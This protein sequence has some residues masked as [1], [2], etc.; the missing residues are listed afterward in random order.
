MKKLGLRPVV[1]RG[2]DSESLM[3]TM[4]EERPTAWICHND[5]LAVR[6]IDVLQSAGVSVPRDVSVLGVDDSPT[7]RD[8]WPQLS[9]MRYPM[10]GMARRVVA[11]TLGESELPDVE[12]ML[13]IERKTVAD[14][15]K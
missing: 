2:L 11:A 10:A 13:V 6:M 9:T 12:P 8:V 14:C 7:L 15:G 1:V 4:S 3:R 5:W